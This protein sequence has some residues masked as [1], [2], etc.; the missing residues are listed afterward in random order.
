MYGDGEGTTSKMKQSS[1]S[2]FT[3]VDLLFPMMFFS[4]DSMMNCK[5][6]LSIDIFS[7]R[8]FPLEPMLAEFKCGLESI[9]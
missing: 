1:I 4:A 5:L 9:F 3:W 8:I 6:S 7:H 2:L